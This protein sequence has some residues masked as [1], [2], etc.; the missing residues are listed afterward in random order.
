MS[1]K[2]SSSIRREESVDT[3]GTFSEVEIEDSRLQE[4]EDTM[5]ESEGTEEGSGDEFYKNGEGY[6]GDIK[7]KGVAPSDRRPGSPL[8]G[9][10]RPKSKKKAGSWSDLDLSLVVALVSPIGNWLTG[11]DHIKN[12]FLILL[13]IFY[14]HQ[15]VEGALHA[16]FCFFCLQGRLYAPSPLAIVSRFAC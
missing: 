14:L 12:L 2:A 7:G 11:S 16:P 8:T 3:I 1:P 6:S 13:L 9:Q 5:S 15:L 4:D 10:H